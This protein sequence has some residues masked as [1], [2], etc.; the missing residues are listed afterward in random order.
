M[1]SNMELIYEECTTKAYDKSSEER[2][3]YTDLELELAVSHVN[4]P[5]DERAKGREKANSFTTT[6][7]R[8]LK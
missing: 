2:I 3:P 7:M 5:S 1:H 8:W 6:N 4:I